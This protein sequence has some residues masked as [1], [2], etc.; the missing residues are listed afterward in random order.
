MIQGV[1][2]YREVVPEVCSKRAFCHGREPSGSSQADVFAECKGLAGVP[3]GYWQH[4]ASR[5]L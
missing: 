2:C 5:D 3:Q 1:G 4:A